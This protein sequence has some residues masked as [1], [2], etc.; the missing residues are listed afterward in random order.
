MLLARVNH[1]GHVP[2]PDNASGFM[3]PDFARTGPTEID[4]E[5]ISR[6]AFCVKIPPGKRYTGSAVERQL[7]E[8][9]LL[10]HCL[11]I[12]DLKAILDT[13]KTSNAYADL[14]GKD[15]VLLG[16]KSTV[17][18]PDHEMGTINHIPALKINELGRGHHDLVICWNPFIS[19]LDPKQ[20]QYFQTSLQITDQVAA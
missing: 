16:W 17:R 10:E 12:D 14:F 1:V 20:P 7:I 5:A 3:Y 18:L 4:I 6:N 8:K 9:G 2:L 15:A 13:L 19:E 11:G